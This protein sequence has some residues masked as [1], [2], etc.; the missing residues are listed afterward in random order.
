MKNLYQ[1][2]PKQL[3]KWTNKE[4]LVSIVFAFEKYHGECYGEQYL[5]KS[6]R[7]KIN[8]KYAVFV[9]KDNRFRRKND[10]K[11]IGIVNLVDLLMLILPKKREGIPLLK[12]LSNSL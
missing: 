11:V 4:K 6:N 3:T 8:P 12:T 5:I 2:F 1:K 10:V 7:R 9:K